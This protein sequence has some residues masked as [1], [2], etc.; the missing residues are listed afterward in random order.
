MRLRIMSWTSPLVNMW[1]NKLAAIGRCL[2]QGRVS[3]KSAH[4][5]GHQVIVFLYES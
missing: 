4:V 2:S 3:I 5:G 1:K